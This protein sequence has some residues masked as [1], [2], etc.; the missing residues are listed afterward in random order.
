MTEDDRQL[1][2]SDWMALRNA[3]PGFETRW[4]EVVAEGTYDDEMPFV[5]LYELVRFVV[6]ELLT[7]RS[8]VLVDIG[9]ALEALFIDAAS[10]GDER[11]EGLLMVGFLEN[12]LIEADNL[13]IPLTRI[14]P[15]LHGR[16]TH[17]HWDRAVT[18]LKPA[19][20]WEDGIGPVASH[21]LPVP[22]GTVEV[23]RGWVD[24]NA[25]ILHLDARLTAGALRPGCVIRHE[26]S[27]DFSMILPIASASLRFQDLPDE[28]HLELAVE[29]EEMFEA[30]EFEM[31]CLA[32][33]RPAT[34]E[35]ARPPSASSNDRHGLDAQD[36]PD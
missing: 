32:F 1:R 36:Q 21:P 12:L 35:V 15:M 34:W 19:F 17:E 33:R 4:R 18:Y 27:K 14:E 23:H 5:N 16:R 31:T 26:V 6:R 11:L 22:I 9:D 20:H 24:R 10:R 25:R 13:R 30:V 8:D 29:R 7:S 28:Y 2:D 3:V